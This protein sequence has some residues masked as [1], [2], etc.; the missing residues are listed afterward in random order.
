MSIPSYI[1]QNRK[2][3]K[4][5]SL[6]N[7]YK[8][9]TKRL[10]LLMFSILALVLVAGLTSAALLLSEPVSEMFTYS[11]QSKDITINAS[12]PFNI[13]LSTSSVFSVNA[14]SSSG[15]LGT[16]KFTFNPSDIHG[17]KQ[18]TITISNATDNSTFTLNYTNSFCEF[19]AFIDDEDGDEK[20]LDDIDFSI[21]ITNNGEGEDDE[22]FALDTIRIEVELENNFDEDDDMDLDD[23]TLELGIFEKSDIDMSNNLAEDMIW[24][25]DED[26]EFDLGDVDGEEN[27]KHTFEFRVDSKEFDEGNYFITVKAYTDEEPDNDEGFC[28]DYSDDLEDFGSSEFYAEISIEAES[29]KEKMVIID[30]ET[31]PKPLEASC[32]EEVTF[33]AEIY[34]IGDKDFEDRVLVTLFNRDL[35]LNL[36][37]VI[38]SDLDAGDRED[39]TFRFRIPRD[40]EEGTYRLSL[41]T[42]YD[43]D[44]DDDK[45][46]EES[47]D[48]F[49]VSLVVKDGCVSATP[50]TTSISANLE[51]EAK[52]GEEMI[53]KT[54]IENT[55]DKSVDYELALNGHSS[56]ASVKSIE[57]S[58]FTLQPDQSREVLLTLNVDSDI[59]GE[60]S[61]NV[62][63]YSNGFIIKEQPVAVTIEPRKGLA[64]ITGNMIG[65]GNWHLWAVGIFNIIL[66]VAIVIVAIKVVKRKE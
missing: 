17:F 9:K 14:T 42:F 6:Q 2:L 13:N 24:I 8:M 18:E 45:Y 5:P 19:R 59:D 32:G 40:T 65:E 3:F 43:Y 7:D 63:V 39:V 58:E 16:F 46:D 55:G 25:S 35:G 23:V 10:S 50:E 4:L 26:E 33:T 20:D 38:M 47:E 44:E 57:P 56:W 1:L 27:S 60:K 41:D 22:W 53:I 51:S 31:L 34:N 52:A 29:D 36:Q 64:A 61:F 54:T 30:A 21:D 28:I 12:N 48:T 49:P 62:G 37:E 15:S 11:G 66:I